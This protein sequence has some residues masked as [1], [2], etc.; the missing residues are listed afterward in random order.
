M[1]DLIFLVGVG[2]EMLSCTTWRLTREREREREGGR[3]GSL[4]VC[5]I[6]YKHVAVQ[7]RCHTVVKYLP[8]ESGLR[9]TSEQVR[10]ISISQQSTKIEVG[11][12]YKERNYSVDLVK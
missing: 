5:Y 8:V 9:T 3:A 10:N 1:T 7:T 6:Y 4:S 12:K 11:V 2:E